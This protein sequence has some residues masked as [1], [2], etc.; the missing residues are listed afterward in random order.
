[1]SIRK[2]LNAVFG[3]TRR[4]VQTI[5]LCDGQSDCDGGEDEDIKLCA[6]R[7]CSEYEFKCSTGRCIP[8]SWVCDGA[9]D[10]ANGGDER[11]CGP[12]TGRCNDQQFM[13]ASDKRCI[14]AKFRCDGDLDCVDKS[15]EQNCD[16]TSDIIKCPEKELPCADG[17]TC[18][19]EEQKCD[20]IAHCLDYSDERD[21]YRMLCSLF[22]INYDNLF[23]IACD[24]TTFQC[25]IPSSKC[26]PMSYVCDGIAQCTDNSDEIFCDCNEED[27]FYQEGGMR[28]QTNSSA[29]SSLL[30]RYQCVPKIKICDGLPDCAN[31][32]IDEDPRVCKRN[33]CATS[34]LRCST[35]NHCYPYSGY[36]DGVAD[37]FDE[38]DER[39]DYCQTKCLGAFRCE[40]ARCIDKKL[41]CNGEDNCGDLSDEQNCGQHLCE[42]FGMC[43]QYCLQEGPMPKCY[44]HPGYLYESNTKCKA[45]D[46]SSAVAV[47]FNGR[48]MQTFKNK[49]N[50]MLLDVTTSELNQIIHNFDYLSFDGK[51]VIIYYLDGNGVVKN[52]SLEDIMKLNDNMKKRPKRDLLSHKELKAENIAIDWIHKNVYTVTYHAPTKDGKIS[53][54]K[55]SD[56]SNSVVLVHTNLGKVTSIAISIHERRLYWSVQEPFAVIESA[57]LDGTFRSTLISTDIYEPQSI[58]VDDFNRRIYWIDIQKGSIES[59]R[60]DGSDRRMIR[61]YGYKNGKLLD[62]PTSFDIFDDYFYILG[63]PGGSVWRT[64]KFGIDKNDTI[65]RKVRANNPMAYLKMI[66]PTKRLA[67]HSTICSA[68]NVC[69]VQPCITI[70]ETPKCICAE[71]EKF[72]GLKCSPLRTIL[73]ARITKCG[74]YKCQNGG[75]CDTATLTCKCPPGSHGREC[76]NT[77]CHNY[78]LNNATC[79]VSYNYAFQKSKALCGCPIQYMGSRCER[80]KCTG[81]CGAHGTCLIDE[82]SGLTYCKCDN[83]WHGQNCDHYLSETGNACDGFCKNG[84]QCFIAAQTKPFCKCPEGFMGLNCENCVTSN[85]D[86]IVCLNGGQCSDEQNICICPKGFLGKSCEIDMCRNY[87]LNGGE[88]FRNGTMYR[89]FVYCNCN[90]G[91]SGD[92]CEKDSCAQNPGYCKN[93]G[94]CVHQTNGEPSC[95]CLSMFTGKTC[96]EDRKCQDYCLNES[97]CDVVQAVAPDPLNPNPVKQWH[98]TCKPGYIGTRCDILERCNGVCDN[99]APCRLD[100]RYGPICQCPKGLGGKR[101]DTVNATSCDEID[102]LNGGQCLE[103]SF[104]ASGCACRFGWYGLTCSLPTC[105][106]YCANAGTCFMQDNKPICAC[107]GNT[108][109]SRCETSLADP[110]TPSQPSKSLGSMMTMLMLILFLC[111]LAISGLY[112]VFVK[113]DQYGIKLFRHHRMFNEQGEHDGDM[114]EFRNPA[115]MIGDDDG[116]S[117]NETTNFTNPV[118]DSDVYNDTVV[119]PLDPPDI[120]PTMVVVSSFSKSNSEKKKLLNDPLSDIQS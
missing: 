6:N 74:D 81:L 5:H 116:T 111:I 63:Q 27:S 104:G 98:C 17:I 38:S 118:F 108:L 18:F 51:S 69:G 47:L 22:E 7:T 55:L 40:N 65:V 97:E 83:G 4:C 96:E 29:A 72:D 90:K 105:D 87:C 64:H 94:I 78:C 52:G 13:C 102:C 58:V 42:T 50:S 112:L 53:I 23:F 115:F 95:A 39:N 46:R 43:S 9:S 70:N 10:C 91:F 14:L 77:I 37:C 101:C 61:K 35:D 34:H 36:C 117:A 75:A 25:T 49:P 84:G 114:D 67:N 59:A 57:H 12:I 16:E 120:I 44:C 30:H 73:H 15:D 8:V 89:N 3:A 33:T 76:Q 99:G 103:P 107:P 19:K 31:G 66:H 54:A 86:E 2:F 71:D 68:A 80:Y 11:D 32:G 113:N 119:A 110:T 92:R 62:R 85:G 106:G 21:C 26:I 56:P 82:L 109:G 48:L 100:E 93:G 79:L 45:E 88:C 41:Q 28:C 20:G 1:M 60:L 24:N